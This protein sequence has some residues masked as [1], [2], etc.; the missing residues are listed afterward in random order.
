[1]NTAQI[2]PMSARKYRNIPLAKIRVLNSRNRD[3]NQFSENIR[4]IDAVGLLKPIVVNERPFEKHGYYALVCGEG[5]FLAYTTLKKDSIPAEVINC[6]RKTALLFSLVENIARVPPKT[7]S[8]AREMKRMKDCGLNLLRISQIVGRSEKDVTDYI[9]LVEM[10]E[11]RLIVGVEQGLFSISF[12]LAVAKATDENVQTVLMDAFDSGIIDSTNVNKIR[13]MIEL[14]LNRGKKP[15]QS[16]TGVHPPYTLQELKRDIVKA[17]EKKEGFVR[18]SKAKENRVL[19]LLDGLDT[20]WKDE[21]FV[22]LVS[23][24]GFGE[25]PALIGNYTA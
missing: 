14:R 5:R 24:E 21:Q 23:T 4:S 19:N 12:A 16:K 1:M 3:K 7:I 6:D 20:L 22:A 9:R 2:V 8:F 10:G 17:T 18:E 15:G 25:R 11:E 13:I